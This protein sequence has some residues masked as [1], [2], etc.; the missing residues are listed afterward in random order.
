MIS[1]AFLGSTQFV[2][3]KRYFY[4]CQLTVSS[5]TTDELIKDDKHKSS[6]K[7]GGYWNL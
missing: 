4:T 1:V 5:A 3:L 2:V 7:N 6:L